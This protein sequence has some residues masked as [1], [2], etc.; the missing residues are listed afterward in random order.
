[1]PDAVREPP[2]DPIAAVTHPD[3][4]PYYRQLRETRPLYFD[5]GLQL[6][7][8][9]S[10]A[11]I[12]EALHHRAL[13]VRPPGEAVPAAL[14]GAPAGQVFARLVRMTDGDFHAAHKP[15]VVE[16]VRRWRLAEVAAASAAAAADLAP[17]LDANT[18]LG[19]LPV[20]TIARLL[21]VPDRQLETTCRQVQAFVQGIAPGAPETAVALASEAAGA[22]MAQGQAEGLDA[23]MA[24]NR[25]A[26]MQQSLDATAGLLGHTVLM[27]RQHP[28]LAD[29]A[30]RSLAAMRAFVSEVERQQAPIQNT[31]RFAAQALQLAG[32]PIGKG[33]GVLLLLASGNRDPALNPQP[34]HF[35]VQRSDRRSLGFGAGAHACPGVAIAIETVAVGVMWTRAGGRFDACFGRLAG[36]RPLGNAR[37]PV[38]DN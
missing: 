5:A 16:S 38:F 21:R 24:A 35:D 12:S 8:A 25:M 27:L 28:G 33:Q 34:D 15:A 32:Q 2:A 7:V 3:P 23:V 11:A 10:Q 29:A 36:F 18:L 14:Q 19:R 9:S 22:L 20:Q 17:R 37:I 6:W 1:M 4:W 13:T 30:D 26:L 31:R